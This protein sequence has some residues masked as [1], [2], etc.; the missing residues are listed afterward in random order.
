M[1]LNINC[2]NIIPNKIGSAK[3]LG[4]TGVKFSLQGK[5]FVEL[6]KFKYQTQ[7]PE[8]KKEQHTFHKICWRKSPK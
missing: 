2:D 4:K 5:S 8:Y 1:S 6:A 3:E 7:I